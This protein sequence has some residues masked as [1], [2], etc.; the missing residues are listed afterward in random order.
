MCMFKATK[1][2]APVPPAQMQQMQNPKDLTQSRDNNRLR[3]RRRGMF[4]SIMTSPQGVSGAPMTT[5]G[6]ASVTGA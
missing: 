3:L 6:G 1:V 5:G 4:A 2:P